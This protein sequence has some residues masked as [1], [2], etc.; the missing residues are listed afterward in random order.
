MRR[1]RVV[2]TA[3]VAGLLLLVAAPAAAHVT[4]NP[5]TIE[6]DSFGAFALRVP[7]GCGDSG[8][9]ELSVQI[10]DEVRSVT[11]EQV[12]GWTVETVTGELDEPYEDHGET[13]TEG[14]VEV[15]WTADEGQVLPTDQF[16]EFGMSVRMADVDEGRVY[17]PTIQ[18]C[19]EGEHA[20]VE[21]PGEGESWGDLDEPAPYLDVTAA[22][23]DGHGEADTDADEADDTTTP[24][25][26]PAD[27]DDA[28]AT[29]GEDDELAADPAAAEA[30]TGLVSW[31]ALALGALGV[32][33]GGAA[34]AAS[35]R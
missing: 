32:A 7:H 11:P 10:P 12:P 22:A 28:T 26:D 31:I 20:W 4:A 18:V 35:R 8:T 14:V 5:N 9:V 3:S 16:R 33:V 21:I 2:A 25:D 34:F 6:S 30:G 17:L 24:D 19:E 15:T 1:L 23:A 27:S 29:N 13:V